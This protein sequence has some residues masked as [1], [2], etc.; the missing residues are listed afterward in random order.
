MVNIFKLFTQGGRRD[1]AREAIN[2][3]LTKENITRYAANG[4]NALLKKPLSSIED[5]RLKVYVANCT[6]GAELFKVIAKAIEDKQITTE[7]A[8]EIYSRCVDL[9]G[10]FISQEQLQDFTEKIVAKIP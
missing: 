3:Y 2:E 7:E 10:S 8:S 4:V 6:E 5:E 1:L 9:F